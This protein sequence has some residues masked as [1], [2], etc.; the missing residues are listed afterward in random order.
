VEPTTSLDGHPPIPIFVTIRG[1]YVV[2][3]KDGSVEG[4][5]V[6]VNVM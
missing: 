5:F 6:V 4:L 2:K 1:E 3:S